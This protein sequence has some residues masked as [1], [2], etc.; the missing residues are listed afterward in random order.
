MDAKQFLTVNISKNV[1][2]RLYEDTKP[3]FLEI[4]PLQKGLV[5]LFG[6]RELI[7]EGIGFGVPVI[8]YEDKTFF[9]SSATLTIPPC[10]KG[11]VFA[12]SFVIDT[13][14]RKRIG[15]RSY[16]NDKIYSFFRKIFEKAYL[17]CR[18]TASFF[19]LIMEFRNALNVQTDF[20][21][22]KPRGT[23]TVTYTC[24]PEEVK[25]NVDF[26]KLNRTGCSQILVLNEQGATFF[27]KYHDT[28]SLMLTN[29]DISAWAIVEA[30]E[31]S[32]SDLAGSLTFTLE[33]LK[34][35]QL[36]KGW[37][38][39]RGR[40]CWAGLSYALPADSSSFEYAIRLHVSN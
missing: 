28:D 6:G 5:L 21:K 32:L 18:K 38:K 7:D 9:S 2:F 8:K 40:F 31:A 19:N 37:E 29:R 10:S 30:K 22:T 3:H 25:V 12:K 39:T 13:I 4:S 14:S 11:N 24:L 17:N 35:A 27:R 34:T 15:E 36:L 23:V 26:T 1:S 33:K 20:V 16:I